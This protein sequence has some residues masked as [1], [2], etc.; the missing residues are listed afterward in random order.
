MSEKTIPKEK[1]RDEK[2]ASRTITKIWD[3]TPADHNSYLAQECR[4]HGY[5]LL[6]L[7]QKRSFVDIFYLILLGELPSAEHAK[8]LETL[9]ISF[10]NPGPRHPAARAAM[11]AGVVKTN[12]AHILPIALNVISGKHLGGEEVV[13]SMKFFKK[14]LKN[15][16]K[17]L[18]VKLFKEAIPPEQGDWHIAPGFG[19]RFGD[20][21]PMPQKIAKILIQLPGSGK[22]LQ[23]SDSFA[24]AIKPYNM[25]FLSPG[26]CAA[27]FYDLG[28]P[29]LAGA[30]LFQF[31]SSPGLLAHGLEMTDKPLTAMPFLDDKHYIIDE[32]AKKRKE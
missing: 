11:N 18:A 23:W 27:V 31:I 8:L 1:Q 22:A 3:E 4:C 29:P 12:S 16:P 6:E 28:F 15:D 20:V 13:A 9:M 25:G 24:K 26:V 30:G 5:D 21:D 7:M 32:A 14:N 2:F 17:K 19:C 10:I